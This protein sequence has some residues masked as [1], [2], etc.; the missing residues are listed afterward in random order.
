MSNIGEREEEG[1][2]LS[3]RYLLQKYI[4]AP[5]ILKIAELLIQP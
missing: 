1:L 2:K 5:Y 3:K 4:I